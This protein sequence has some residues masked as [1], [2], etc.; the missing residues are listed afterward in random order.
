MNRNTFSQVLDPIL[1]FVRNITIICVI[2]IVFAVA[3]AYLGRRTGFPILSDIVSTL[4]ILGILLMVTGGLATMSAP[5]TIISRADV[6]RTTVH[7]M[8][9]M[10]LGPNPWFGVGLSLFLSGLILGTIAVIC[11]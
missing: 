7:E 11:A 8:Q 2:C 5:G 6:S 1:Y 9:S 4:G 3:A 10:R